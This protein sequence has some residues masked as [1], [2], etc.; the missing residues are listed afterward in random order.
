MHLGQVE[1]AKNKAVGIVTL[2][3]VHLT[4]S[5]RLSDNTRRLPPNSEAA[6]RPGHRIP[7]GLRLA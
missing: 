3:I 1:S 4:T 6:W 2:D 7:L 5:T